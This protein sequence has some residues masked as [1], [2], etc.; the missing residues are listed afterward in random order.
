MTYRLAFLEDAAKEWR[1]LDNPTKDRLA[2]KIDKLL[3]Q[4]RVPAMALSGMK[5]CYKI[6]FKK[7]PIRLVYR[8]F[9]DVLV[10]EVVAIGKRDKNE[11][12]DMA[13]E[14]LKS[15]APE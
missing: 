11:V 14:R 5:D 1:K 3:A 7:P 8:V 4:P 2:K 6:K 9:D 10:F 12:Y 13:L 15:S